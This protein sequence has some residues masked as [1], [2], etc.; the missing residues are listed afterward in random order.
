MATIK[1]S[2][3]LIK[4]VYFINVS[5]NSGTA[6]T[7]LLSGQH[8]IGKSQIVREAAKELKGFCF[9]IDGSTT[10]EGEVTGLPFAMKDENG[11]SVLRFIKHYVVNKIANIE[12]KYYE[13]AT[14]KGFLDGKVK[15]VIDSTTN[16]KTLIDNTGREEFKLEMDTS[17]DSVASGEDNMYKFGELLPEETKMK[18]L[19]SGEIKP[20]I[21]F[22][23]ELNRTESQTMKELMNIILNKTVNGY[24]FPWWLNIVSAINPC[25]QNSAYATREMDPAQLDRFLRIKVSPNFDEWVD[26][27]FEVGGDSEVIQALANS[28]GGAIFCDTDN[29]TLED[30]SKILPSPRDWDMVSLIHKS[31]YKN[32]DLP[33]FDDDE[34]ADVD[35]DFR[36]LV[37]GKVGE[38]AARVFLQSLDNRENLI[39]PTDILTMKEMTI[40]KAVREKF[41]SSK[42]ITQKVISDSIARYLADNYFELKKKKSSPET[43]DRTAYTCFSNQ[44]KEFVNL[45]DPATQMLFVK[46]II[47]SKASSNDGSPNKNLERT[48]VFAF[49]APA[50]STEVLS[51]LSMAKSGLNDLLN[52][53]DK[54]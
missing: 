13:I 16:K 22:I 32:N 26:H 52:N 51:N 15:L 48:S 54:K 17:L 20:A 43:A 21:M 3:T 44:L 35:N 28:E 46:K 49:Y 33:Y 5:A 27:E 9:I 40:N 18:L 42:R 36:T 47:I 23:D 11:N 53:S 24:D 29:K 12:K 4:R 14:T 19:L 6:I 39:K 31:I 2:K 30:A 8:G 34:K 38:D 1:K 37:R 41:I 25:S 10:N 50:F 45:L 7:L